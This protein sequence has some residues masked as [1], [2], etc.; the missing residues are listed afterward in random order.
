MASRTLDELIEVTFRGI[1]IET[2][3]HPALLRLTGAKPN[4]S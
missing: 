2:D 3:D 4:L 1:T